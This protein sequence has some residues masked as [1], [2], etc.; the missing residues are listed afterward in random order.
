MQL[1]FIDRLWKALGNEVDP[2]TGFS[3]NVSL[4]REQ[5]AWGWFDPLTEFGLG[6]LVIGPLHVRV[7]WPL[8]E[9][10]VTD[11]L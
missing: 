1:K 3:I 8:A 2:R 6:V 9:W 11:P 5:W 10:P 4:Y 7:T